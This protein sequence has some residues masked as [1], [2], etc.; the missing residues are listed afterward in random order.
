MN[1]NMDDAIFDDPEFLMLLSLH[2]RDQNRIKKRKRRWYV[3]PINI[4]RNLTSVHHNLIKELRTRDRKMYFTYFRMSPE[5]FDHLLS[6]LQPDLCSGGNHRLP[7]SAAEKLALTLRLLASGDE[8]RSLAFYYRIG[9]KT[10]NKIFNQTCAVI[11]NRLKDDYVKFPNSHEEWRKIADDYWKFWQFPLCLGSLDGKH[12][13][14][15]APNK[16]G[17]MFFNYKHY[18]SIILMAIVDSNYKFIYVDIGGYG[19]Q[20]DSGTF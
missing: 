15:K 3:R 19:S 2:I 13:A 17:S 10:I 9:F 18:F 1:F 5:Q 20:N 14:I 7:I 12:I 16:T 4:S 11:W 6:K 8:Q